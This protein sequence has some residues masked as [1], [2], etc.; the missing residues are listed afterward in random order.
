MCEGVSFYMPISNFK[1]KSTER[2]IEAM[3]GK[4][5]LS[6]AKIVLYDLMEQSKARHFI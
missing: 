2:R 1:T 3:L 6:S 4:A 5:F